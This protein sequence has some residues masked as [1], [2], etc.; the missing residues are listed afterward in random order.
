MKCLNC[1]K[2]KLFHV[3]CKCFKKL[4]LNCLPYY[5]HN[6][7][8]DYKTEKK[9]ILDNNNPRIEAEKIKVI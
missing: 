9:S 6:C 4:C 1:N 3:E 7:T 5:V 8:Y 2:K